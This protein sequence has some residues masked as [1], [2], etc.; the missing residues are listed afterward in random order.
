MS[1]VIRIPQNIYKRLERHSIGFESPIQVIEKLLNFYE[2]NSTRDQASDNHVFETAIDLEL[3]EQAFK[4]VFN[5]EPRKFGQKSSTL[6]GYSDNAKGV[7]WNIGIVAATRNVKLGVNLEGMSYSNKWPIRNFIQ[8]E[9]NTLN[10]IKKF[11]NNKDITVRL[12]RDAWQVAS[13]LPIE[14]KE[15]IK[16]KISNIST[17][18]WK[19]ALET[20][21]TCLNS[22]KDFKGRVSQN[23]TLIPSGKIVEREVSPHISFKL[24]LDINTEKVTLNLLIEEIEEGKKQLQDIHNLL[25]KETE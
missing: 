8:N 16:A 25:I 19:S 18:K 9:L 3:L 4:T 10:L 23:V 17:L 24:K 15:I 13:R 22:D 2:D 1:Q 21:L 14:E 11:G 7:Q 12:D 20:A 6:S 5:V